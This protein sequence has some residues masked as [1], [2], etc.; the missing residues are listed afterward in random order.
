MKIGR[1]EIKTKKMIFM[2]ILKLRK[3]KRKIATQKEE[4][5]ITLLLTLTLR[6]LKAPENSAFTHC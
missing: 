5:L 3:N 4:I 2:K 1:S 6:L